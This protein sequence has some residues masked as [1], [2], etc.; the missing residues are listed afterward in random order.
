MRKM[1]YQNLNRSF[2]EK[3][4]EIAHEGD[5]VWVHD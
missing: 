4:L 1:T 5:L 3:V 2:A